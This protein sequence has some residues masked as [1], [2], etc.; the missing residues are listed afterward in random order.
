[1]QQ[2]TLVPLNFEWIDQ[3]H[4]E[5]ENFKIYCGRSKFVQMHGKTTKL[6]LNNIITFSLCNLS[7]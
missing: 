1:M 3:T 2:S 4:K 7:L 5:I 6:I